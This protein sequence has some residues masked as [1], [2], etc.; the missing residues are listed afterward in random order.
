MTKHENRY[1]PNVLENVPLHRYLEEVSGL[2]VDKKRVI[3]APRF[4]ELK[5]DRI[6]FQIMKRENILYR[7]VFDYYEGYDQV[8]Q[9]TN[10][11]HRDYYTFI[12]TPDTNGNAVITLEETLLDEQK[13]ALTGSVQITVEAVDLNTNLGLKQQLLSLKRGV[14]R[15]FSELYINPN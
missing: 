15:T 2:Q 10:W 1:L 12:S 6:I 11:V 9:P 14:D 4:V 8:P 13:E 3:M 5:N 7:F